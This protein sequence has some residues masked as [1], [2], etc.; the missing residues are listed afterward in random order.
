MPML[1]NLVEGL[2]QLVV[3]AKGSGIQNYFSA[4]NTKS[5]YMAKILK[6]YGFA[7]T[8]LS[9]IH[10]G[11]KPSSKKLG[12][13]RGVAYFSPLNCEESSSTITMI[14]NKISYNW[15]V[16][17]FLIAM[18]RKRGIR[19]IYIFDDNSVLLP[20]LIAL[21]WMDVIELV[22]NIE[23]WPLA[24]D[25][26][27]TKKVSSHLFSVLALK[28]CNKVVC[29]SEY[30]KKK[31]FEYNNKVNIFRLPAITDFSNSSS[32]SNADYNKGKELVRF[33]Y[34]GNVGYTQVIF[35]IID[36][37][38]DLFDQIGD[39]RIQLILI[40]HG[41]AL[42]MSNVLNRV[43]G[44][45]DSI[46]IK[47]SLSEADL[48][49]EYDDATCLL[50]PLRNTLQDQARFQQKI[51]EYT[52]LSKPIITNNVGDVGIYFEANKSAIFADDFSIS[53]IK[54]KMKYVVD[55]IDKACDIGVAG[56]SVGKKY[57][58]YEAYIYT[59]GTFIS[60]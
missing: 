56:Y 26:A 39:K 59:F 3:V 31:A 38:L 46:L 28:T 21:S 22:F 1:I 44:F 57:F 60:K 55:N 7:V 58:N 36:A 54:N 14:V 50:A 47:K 30:L 2:N 6:R 4:V 41:D 32:P 8:I 37:F 23:E 35:N 42:L 13:F 15:I 51:S 53:N 49:R 24:H 9:S 27:F 34:C 12:K 33:L 19:S 48:Y 29:V 10:Y 17:L 45:E 25:L 52:S 11:D 18:K 20:I 5:Y 40:I 16:V 43:S